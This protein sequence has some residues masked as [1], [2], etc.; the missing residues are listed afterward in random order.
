MKRFR[1]PLLVGLV[2][3]GSVVVFVLL[4][5]T[6]EKALVPKGEGYRVTAD[7]D[8]VSG[9][10]GHSR[11][12]IA[13]IPVGTIDSIRLVKI[14]DTVNKARVTI[15]LRKDLELYAGTPGPE[16]IPL[17]ASTITRR[18][19]SIMGDYYLDITPGIAGERLKEGDPIPIVIQEAG[20]MALAAKLEKSGDIFPRLQQIADDVKVITGAVSA[21]VGG[22]MGQKRL[23][24]IAID[25]AQAADRIADMST[26][27]RNFVGRSATGGGKLD[28]ILANAERFTDD[29]SDIAR[30]VAK[31]TSTNRAS[32]DR[33]VHN[34]EVISND[35]RKVLREDPGDPPAGLAA[36]LGKLET[37]LT[38]LDD[39]TR[40]L[41]SVLAKIDGGQ[42]T[43]G[44]LVNDDK[45]AVKTEEVITD[46]GAIVK[47]VSD[48]KTQIGF[49]TEFNINERAFK[50]YLSLRFQ[51]R[52]ERYYLME[53]AFD[54][55][56]RTTTT[57]RLTLT[58]AMDQ[59]PI[60]KERITETKEAVKFTFQFA[61]R[62]WFLTARF[63]LIE[64]TGGLGLDAEFLKDSMKFGFDLFN[65]TADQYP[66]LRAAWTWEFVKHFYVTA[67]VDDIANRAGRDYFVGGGFRFTDEDLKTLLVAA[68]MPSF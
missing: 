29:A 27:V 35:L 61:Y 5:G 34:I 36:A 24:G 65:F 37:T 43:V 6:V 13:G 11:V 47:S 58:N 16:G 26:E 56:G 23:E 12:T 45:I 67:G 44:R 41:N 25:V 68:P 51:T 66:R 59:T 21:V 63:G 7:F 19:A 50:N 17:N 8:D 38:N 32:L 1:A 49:R 52:P 53:V 18:T 48:L 40:H 33:T 28:R 39:A 62:F 22:E 4:Y 46:V 54:P 30:D 64:T 9:L 14:S 31:F 20:F 3:I 55:R 57:D 15:R 42:G 10:A 2:G 60:L